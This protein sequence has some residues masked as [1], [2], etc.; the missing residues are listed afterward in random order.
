MFEPENLILTLTKEKKQGYENS[1]IDKE[2]LKK[3]IKDFNQF[4][5]ICGPVQFIEDITKFLKELGVKEDILVI[6]A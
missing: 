3:Y 5:Y 4:F 1:L 2:F 6:E